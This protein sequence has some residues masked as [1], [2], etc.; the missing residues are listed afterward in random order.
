[1]GPPPGMPPHPGMRPPFPGGPPPGESD[2]V[3]CLLFIP[4]QPLVAIHMSPQ[5]RT[6]RQCVVFLQQ[7]QL[8]V[9]HQHP[10]L[11]SVAQALLAPV[12]AGACACCV[13]H[14]ILLV[15]SHTCAA[16]A[17]AV[18]VAAAAAAAPQVGPH[19]GWV[20]HP[21]VDPQADHPSTM[22]LLSSSSRSSS[23]G[24]M[25]AAAAVLSWGGWAVGRVVCWPP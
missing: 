17:A 8:V 14:H 2:T 20:G 16:A 1:M 5:R 10:A 13:L 18:A 15:Y 21:Q 4:V 11:E 25:A 23:S 6:R 24:V 7:H 12:L 19:M 9:Q 22:D 3:P